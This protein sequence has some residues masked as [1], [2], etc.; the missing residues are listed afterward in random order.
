MTKCNLCHKDFHEA[1]LTTLNQ[2]V[3][4]KICKVRALQKEFRATCIKQGGRRASE[5]L[6]ED[7]EVFITENYKFLTVTQ[8]AVVLKLKKN[9]ISWFIKK[10]KL[11]KRKL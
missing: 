7:Q 9:T 11:K 1:E 10:N 3:V 8:L 6:T 4:C 5:T 2:V